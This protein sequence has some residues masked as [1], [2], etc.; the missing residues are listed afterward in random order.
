ML[1]FPPVPFDP[2]RS[3]PPWALSGTV[4]GA[5]L[6]HRVDW[7]GLG[8]AAEAPP[9]KGRAKAPVL[10][11]KPRNT[12][13]ADD[14]RGVTVEVPAGVD[15]LEVGA[16]LAIVIGEPACRVAV[17]DALRH[18]AGYTLAADIRIAHGGPNQ[19][20]RHYRPA[21]RHRARDGF[22]PLGPRIVPA[23]AITKPDELII[24]VAV[25][26]RP[27]HRAGTGERVRGVA[28]LIADVSAFM[29]LHAG[30]LLLLGAPPGAPKV[31]AGQKVVIALAPIGLLRITLVAEEAEREPQR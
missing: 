15:A 7:Q 4:V 23:W 28:Q 12:L 30:D 18:V 27:G 26:G 1:R 14:G 8:A 13:V 21:V 6:N 24:D 29:T 20:D 5:L 31:S 10:Q 3:A 17:S 25:D 16:T 2:P 9:Y 11:V 22:C 19:H